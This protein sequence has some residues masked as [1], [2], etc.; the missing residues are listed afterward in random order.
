[1]NSL[2][3]LNP[4]SNTLSVSL[5]SSANVSNLIP[6]SS[7]YGTDSLSSFNGFSN[8]GFSDPFREWDF[9][10][11]EMG[12]RFL[13]SLWDEG[14]SVT[15]NGFQFQ[16]DDTL[17]LDPQTNKLLV[18]RDGQLIDPSTYGRPNQTQATNANTTVPAKSVPFNMSKETSRISRSGQMFNALNIPHGL[19]SNAFNMAGLV[20][21]LGDQTGATIAAGIYGQA[22]L[23][24][25]LQKTISIINYL[26]TAPYGTSPNGTFS[27]IAG[28]P[29]YKD[30]T[31]EGQRAQ[32]EVFAQLRQQIISRLMRIAEQ[33]RL[34]SDGLK[35][36]TQL[37]ESYKKVQDGDVK[38]F[39]DAAFGGGGGG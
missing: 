8:S 13:S 15:G 21:G 14:R 24:N 18:L 36:Q 23:Y 26:N 33:L 25:Q 12:N 17:Y 29:A 11:N 22:A 7:A 27:Y 34:A 3:F 5:G 6:I 35:Q 37:A 30:D 4:G 10:S 2:N 38:K 39:V 20:P 16:S 19:T 1:M 9:N 32:A 31:P 28:R